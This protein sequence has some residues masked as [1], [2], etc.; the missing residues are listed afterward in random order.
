MTSVG[1]FKDVVCIHLIISVVDYH[2]LCH[3]SV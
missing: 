1:V 3:V 2:L